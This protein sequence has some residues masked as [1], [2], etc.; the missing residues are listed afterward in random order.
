MSTLK[1]IFCMKARENDLET[2]QNAAQVG[3]ELALTFYRGIRFPNKLVSSIVEIVVYSMTRQDLQ[4]RAEELLELISKT[5]GREGLR[6][7]FEVE[8][9]SSSKLYQVFLNW[10]DQQQGPVS[11]STSEQ[12]RPQVSPSHKKGEIYVE[13]NNETNT[14]QD[15]SFSESPS[16]KD[17][18]VVP[19]SH[20]P[21]AGVRH[22]FDQALEEAGHHDLN[23]FSQIL[24][25]TEGDL[26]HPNF[27]TQRESANKTA[28]IE[29]SDINETIPTL[30]QFKQ[31][32]NGQYYFNGQPGTE[33]I[34]PNK[35][36]EL[37]E[38]RPTRT[39]LG[40]RNMEEYQQLPPREVVVG[41]QMTVNREDK[42][43]IQMNHRE[44]KLRQSSGSLNNKSAREDSAEKWKGKYIQEKQRL[45]QTIDMLE[46]ANNSYLN[47][48]TEKTDLVTRLNEQRQLSENLLNKFNE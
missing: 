2:A 9:I 14:L 37:Q 4:Q 30:A 38:K 47:Q 24:T 3:L 36:T 28:S 43:N 33:N 35:K 18:Q 48:V 6:R 44:D 34:E 31:N 19:K 22:S 12:A 26:D 29:R 7:I 21:K 32:L 13:D 11:V 25:T 42:E 10:L 40:E 20:S 8:L 1:A 23:Q 41:H 45:Q 27:G 15:D 16:P 17:H 39:V 5:T 46:K